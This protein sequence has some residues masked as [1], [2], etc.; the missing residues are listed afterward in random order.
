MFRSSAFEMTLD[1][2]KERKQF[3]VAVGSFQALQHRMAVL[4]SELEV[5]KAIVQ[6]GLA[7]L[8]EG[9]AEVSMLASLAK[10][11]LSDLFKQVACESIQLHGGIGMTDEHDIG[12]FMKRSHVTAEL[13]GNA[14]FHRDRYAGILEF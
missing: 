10:A 11:K 1:Y 3:G 13:F 7:A 2:L 6:R 9:S 4:Y 12:F 14:G 8:D 5:S